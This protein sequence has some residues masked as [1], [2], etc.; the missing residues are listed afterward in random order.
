[1]VVC[2]QSSLSSQYV[3]EWRVRS[4]DDLR[5]V[6]VFFDNDDDMIWWHGNCGH[7]TSPLACFSD[8]GDMILAIE[9]CPKSG[10]HPA[11]PERCKSKADLPARVSRVRPFM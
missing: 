1:M 11:E 7:R 5:V 2:E 3:D 8:V 10:T 6:L 4:S 9:C